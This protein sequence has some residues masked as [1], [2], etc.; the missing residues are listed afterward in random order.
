MPPFTK[1]CNACTSIIYH[2]LMQYVLPNHYPL[3]WE[4][5]I[6]TGKYLCRSIDYIIYIAHSS[7]LID[8]GMPKYFDH[9]NVLSMA[10]G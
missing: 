3:L 1:P 5:P 2:T 7:Q 8:I 4:I 10:L 9:H 6:I